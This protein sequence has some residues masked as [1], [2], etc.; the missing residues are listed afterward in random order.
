MMLQLLTNTHKSKTSKQTDRRSSD[1]HFETLRVS[2][3]QE[4]TDSTKTSLS[5]MT[6]STS[7]NQSIMLPM[8]NEAGTDQSQM[9]PSHNQKL[10][11]LTTL[12]IIITAILMIVQGNQGHC[13]TTNQT[14]D[15]A[16]TV[17][18]MKEQI[19][20]AMR[21]TECPRCRHWTQVGPL[22]KSPLEK[23]TSS[24]SNSP[25]Q[26]STP[27][28]PNNTPIT[29]PC[30]PPSP[31]PLLQLRSKDSGS[32][33]KL[34]AIP[35]KATTNSIHGGAMMIAAIPSTVDRQWGAMKIMPPIIMTTTATLGI[36]AQ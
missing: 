33:E 26:P 11:A 19:R 24:P 25:V 30:L 4:H 32:K 27:T 18:R 2:P 22:Y 9:P 8:T 29:S 21:N 1:Q 6:H 31:I 23:A 16:I 34:T 13:D 36:H 28:T 14:S 12:G 35:G 17:Q 5:T 3:I 7:V 15:K 10:T 20:Q